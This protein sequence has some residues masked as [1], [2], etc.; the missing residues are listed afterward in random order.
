[1]TFHSNKH[2]DNPPSQWLTA[3][4]LLV[5]G[6]VSIVLFSTN[7]TPDMD[8]YWLRW[9]ELGRTLQP[10]AAYATA[11][12]DYPPLTM[13]T[14]WLGGVLFAGITA[15]P[16]IQIKLTLLLTLSISTAIYWRLS[17]NTLL[18]AFFLAAHV[19]GTIGLAYLDIFA[20]LWMVAAFLLL[21]RGIPEGF[22]VLFACALL[23]KWQPLVMM[24]VVVLYLL[25]QRDSLSQKNP[26]N[27]VALLLLPAALLAIA[28][29]FDIHQVL[30]AWLKIQRANDGS[31][32]NAYAFGLQG[33][34]DAAVRISAMI[35]ALQQPSEALA[36][37]HLQAIE[38]V[39]RIGTGP[40]SSARFWIS[41]CLFWFFVLCTL[42]GFV[43]SKREVN[44]LLRCSVQMYVVYFLFRHG[45]HENHLYIPGLLA[46][47]LAARQ[48]AYLHDAVMLNLLHNLNMVYYYSF[49]GRW[50][51]D[52]WL[53]SPA[54]QALVLLLCGLC[55]LWLLLLWQ[56]WLS[57]EPAL[58]S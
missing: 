22:V 6:L 47:V 48:R 18:T 15:D 31:F 9:L 21:I 1:M 51:E 42:V 33:L 30:Q 53:H 45:V 25:S 41:Q 7:G 37:Q 36:L 29:W 11:Q 8:F 49:D 17:R 55:S 52:I 4:L 32:F 27:F 5:T 10:V 20:G 26:R 57:T 24:P 39:T 28:N 34:V 23:T 14:L 46:L 3:S 13:A 40:W 43:R 35:S 44:D 19:I 56:R 58:R 50:P 54:A 2:D 16:L 12:S 38:I